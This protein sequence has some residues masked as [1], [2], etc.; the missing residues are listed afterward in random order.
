[1]GGKKNVKNAVEVRTISDSRVQKRK[2]Q[3]IPLAIKREIKALAHQGF[4]LKEVKQKLDIPYL[5]KQTF[6]NIKKKSY[7]NQVNSRS[8][9]ASYKATD[10]QIVRDFEND[11]VRLYKQKNKSGS[12]PSKFLA[13][14]CFET[15][16]LEKYNNVPSLQKLKFTK[17]YCMRQAELQAEKEVSFLR[18]FIKIFDLEREWS[19]RYY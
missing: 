15:Q 19:D 6:H 3:T 5:P 4:G 11:A 1:M 14:A 7:D 13:R 9:N 8:Y 17:N 18:I 16:K 10:H 12:F 2:Y